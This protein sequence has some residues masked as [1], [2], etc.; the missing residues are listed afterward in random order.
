TIG[1]FVSQVLGFPEILGTPS[2]WPILLGMTAIPAALQLVLLPFCPESPRFLL[3]TKDQEEKAREAL[4]KFRGSEDVESDIS[5]MKHEQSM[6]QAESKVSVWELL[7]RKDLRK[8]LVIGLVMQ[9]SQQFSGILA[10]IYYS[11][12]LFELSGMAP[13]VANHA[14]S[15]IGAVCIIMTFISIPLMESQG[16]RLLH[17]T[18]LMGSFVFSILLTITLVL[19]DTVEVMQIISIV[20]TILFVSAF[21]IGPGSIPWLIVAELFS[22]GSRASAMSLCVMVN[23][24]SNFANGFGFPYVERGLKQLSFVPFTVLLLLFWIFTYMYLPET[25]DKTFQQISDGFNQQKI[26]KQS[27]SEGIAKEDSHLVGFRNVK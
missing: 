15:S 27:K 10:V 6:G 13:D 16:R 20:A 25:K 19:S 5:D 14:N 23:W 17:L 2:S 24:L 18:G 1:I 4:V 8:R 21:C 11:Q 9:L 22:Q 3:I 7:F 26:H 12:S